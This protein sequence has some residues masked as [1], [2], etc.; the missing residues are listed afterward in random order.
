MKQHIACLS[1]DFDAMSGMVARGLKTPT[2]VSRG[3]FGAVAIPRILALL[4]DYEIPATFFIPGTVIGTY[5]KECEAILRAGHEIGNHGW[6]HVPPANLS[7]EKEDEGLSRS[8]EAIRKLT[9]SHPTGYRSPSW[10]LSQ[11]T[12]DLL[13][14]HGFFYESSM[15][16]NDHSPYRV[17]TGDLVHDEEPVE[18]GKLTPLIEMPISWSLDDFPHFEYLRMGQSVAPGLMN[19]S[20]VLENWLADFEY[21]T[22]TE[23]FGILTYTCHPFVIGRGHRMMMLEKLLKG[24]VAMD[25]EF[26]SMHSAAKLYESRSPFK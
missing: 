13:I 24:L 3:E 8:N 10:D 20:S 15:M 5:P 19:A 9:G 7:L 6:T 2:P 12:V 1:F 23:S 11:H 4:K 21:M 26:M 17:R 18:F 22:A 25:A 14:K 16:G